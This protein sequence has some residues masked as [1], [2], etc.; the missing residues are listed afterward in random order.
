MAIYYH[1]LPGPASSVEERSL[2]NMFL[3]SSDCGSN[4]AV[5]Q[6]FFRRNY[7]LSHYRFDIEALKKC[8]KDIA[9]SNRANLGIT[10][11][12]HP[13]SEVKGKPSP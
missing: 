11:V 2:R 1:V 4:L 10:V 7:L 8:Q 12:D 5:R 9:T 3:S 6:V 13:T